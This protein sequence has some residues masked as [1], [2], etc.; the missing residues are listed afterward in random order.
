MN[1]K[2]FALFIP[3]LT[4]FFITVTAT[5]KIRYDN[6]RLFKVI[7]KNERS[8]EFLKKFEDKFD[9]WK[10]PISID[11]FSTVLISPEQLEEFK[12]LMKTNE[13]DI[14]ET[15]SDVQKLIEDTSPS[16]LTKSGLEWTNYH[17]LDEI[18]EWVDELTNQYPDIVTVFDLPGH[19]Y[20]RRPIR[21]LKISHKEGN[22]GIFIEANM[23]AREWISS[24][25][26]TWIINELLTSKNGT[27]RLIAE[28]IDWYFVP[29]LNPDGLVYTHT[30]DRMW[31]KTRQPHGNC[32]GADLNRNYDFLWMEAGAS[33][34]PCSNTY[35]G[36]FPESE[37]E[38]QAITKYFETIPKNKIKIYISFHSFGQLALTP[39]GHTNKEFPPNYDDMLKVGSGF[40]NAA[41]RLYNSN[42]RYGAS[43]VVLYA[44]SGS[45]KEWAY[46][47]QKIPFTFTIELRD[48]GKFGFIL[49]PDQIIPTAREVLEG[50]VGMINSVPKGQFSL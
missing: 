36:P 6:Y 27:V 18:Y 37:P 11:D 5:E 9:F 38:I 35:A 23:H 29:V 40:A 10:E 28:N 30:T 42:Y 4:V 22:P 50:L 21:A 14:E 20:E 3:V 25:T 17:P 48:T 41:R 49:P 33:S 32:V 15:V 7:S 12:D 24:A 1:L 45:S 19:S 43:S 44:V 2:I 13:I 39:W 31:R 8:L 47:V 16:S 34:N 26:A 46:G